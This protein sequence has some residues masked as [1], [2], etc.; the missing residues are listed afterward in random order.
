[1]SRPPMKAIESIKKY[2]EKTQCRR[3]DFGVREDIGYDDY[4]G[5]MLQ[6][7][8]PCDWELRGEE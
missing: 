7:N 6:E 5:C 4:V 1:M 2:C 8:N 3:C